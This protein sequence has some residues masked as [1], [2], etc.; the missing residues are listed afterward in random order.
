MY[1]YTYG[2]SLE[3]NSYL[4]YNITQIKI[5]PKGAYTFAKMHLRQQGKGS[6]LLIAERRMT[7]VK[8]TIGSTMSGPTDGHYEFVSYGELQEKNG[9][10]YVRYEESKA[11][12][13]EGTKTTMKWNE[14]TLTII[15]HG[16]Y[17]HRQE[18][19][20]GLLSQSV[21]T[22]PYFSMPLVTETKVYSAKKMAH[23]WQLNVEYDLTLGENDQGKVILDIR[24]EEEEVSG[25]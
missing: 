11:T 12:G 24:I 13:M 9:I 10:C 6:P 25:H 2:F 7:A 20:E 22:T 16:T 4:Y 19:R 23:G 3:K 17:E 14:E 15:R 18:H 8:I 5:V 1:I 21:Y